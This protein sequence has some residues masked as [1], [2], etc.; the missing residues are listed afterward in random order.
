[1]KAQGDLLIDQKGA[2]PHLSEEHKSV[3]AALDQ[4]IE[5][6]TAADPEKVA[7]LY[8][9]EAVF[10]G[11]ISPFLRTT[12]VGVRDYFEH[13]LQHENLNAFYY[14]PQVRVYGDTAINSGYYTFF[15][16]RDGRMASIPA[17]YTF[18]YRRD[19]GGAWKIVEHHSSAVPQSG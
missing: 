8:A 19:G 4:W 5:A 16:E 13:F 12:P 6:I 17:R 14:K 18:V 9:E 2:F 11:T 15:L 10:W 1:M 3:L 7:R